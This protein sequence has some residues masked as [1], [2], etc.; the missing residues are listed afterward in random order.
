MTEPPSPFEPNL[1]KTLNSFPQALLAAV[2]SAH[3]TSSLHSSSLLKAIRTT[4]NIFLLSKSP[5]TQ[6]VAQAT[7]TQMI[8][9]VFGRIPKG[10][11]EKDFP[12]G[13]QP[14]L[15]FDSFKNQGQGNGY[16]D[17]LTSPI[18]SSGSSTAGGEFSNLEPS[19]IISTSKIDTED[20]GVSKQSEQK[21]PDLS[22]T[23]A[24]TSSL[25]NREEAN[26]NLSHGIT[27]LEKVKSSTLEG[28]EGDG[29]LSVP[30]SPNLNGDRTSIHS[31]A[32]TISSSPVPLNTNSKPQVLPSN[33][34]ESESTA[35]TSVH[36]DSTT[37]PQSDT[38]FEVP[39]DTTNGHARNSSTL[40]SKSIS[41]TR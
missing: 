21:F 18:E 30:S 25:A 39:D 6:I 34:I 26:Q 28:E 20:L 7:L 23:S 5:N 38:F 16:G 1:T 32:P 17:D 27:S 9:A 29:D 14:S 12:I 24:L 36:Q 31:P 37:S 10:I 35:P 22:P 11:T 15:S 33:S 13:F 2:S 3:P 41:G 4:Y 19:Y 8:Q 40:T